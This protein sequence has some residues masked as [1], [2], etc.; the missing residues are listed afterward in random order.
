MSMVRFRAVTMRQGP[1]VSQFEEPPLPILEPLL[2]DLMAA[3]AVSPY[4]LG[5]G[6]EVLGGIN[7]YSPAI[8]ALGTRFLSISS[9]LTRKRSGGCQTG[10]GA[11]SSRQIP[12]NKERS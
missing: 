11:V 5:H 3:D 1:D 2:A 10:F 9:L 6:G 12:I 7:A 8:Y 4:V